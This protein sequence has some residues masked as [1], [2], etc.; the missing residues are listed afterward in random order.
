VINTS[1][2]LLLPYKYWKEAQTMEYLLVHFPDDR[3]VVIDNELQGRT[4]ETIEVEAGTHI[5]SLKSPPENFR[6]G[7]RKVTLTGTSA[8]TPREVSFAKD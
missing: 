2:S 8:L 7:Q 6:P 3:S 1:S 4:N 5:I